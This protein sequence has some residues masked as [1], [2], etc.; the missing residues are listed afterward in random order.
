LCGVSRNDKRLFVG[1]LCGIAFSLALAIL[2][3]HYVHWPVVWRWLES[4]PGLYSLTISALVCQLGG[5]VLVVWEV[6]QANWRL[7]WLDHWFGELAKEM[8]TIDPKALAEQAATQSQT[9]FLTPELSARLLLPYLAYKR[10]YGYLVG[11]TDIL[12]TYPL[13]TRKRPTAPAWLGPTLLLLGIV[14]AGA[15]GLLGIASPR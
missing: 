12:R 10:D 4:M 9:K 14:F 2:L 7:L 15:A 6:S 3:R 8:A 11:V 1:A 13:L 5:V